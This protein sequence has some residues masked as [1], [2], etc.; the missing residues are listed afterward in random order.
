MY[1]TCIYEWLGYCKQLTPLLGIIY[2]ACGQPEFSPPLE[3][4]NTSSVF[5]CIWMYLS[6]VSRPENSRK[7]PHKSC[8]FCKKNSSLE[9]CGIPALKSHM[10]TSMRHLTSCN[11]WLKCWGLRDSPWTNL[12]PW[13]SFTLW[14]LL[15][16]FLA[17]WVFAVWSYEFHQCGRPPTTIC[18]LWLFLISWYCFWVRK[19]RKLR[20][21]EKRWV[22]KK[23]GSR[24]K[25][26]LHLDAWNLL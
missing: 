19:R 8:V 6:S 24:N 1:S 9:I 25:F 20:C 22:A 18:S 17:T 10:T 5:L 23:R 7:K 16:A 13:P 21:V 26:A 11:T 15:L 4:V 2:L 12:C 14:C 3:L